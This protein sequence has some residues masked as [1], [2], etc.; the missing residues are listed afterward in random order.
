[1]PTDASLVL[2]ATKAAMAVAY[3]AIPFKTS[4]RSAAGEG[5]APQGRGGFQAGLPLPSFVGSA[6]DRVVE[7]LST[8]EH[9]CR[10][11]ETTVEYLKSAQARVEDAVDDGSPLV[12]EDEDVREKRDAIFALYKTLAAVDAAFHTKI[13]MLDP[14]DALPDAPGVALA[15]GVRL[16][17]FLMEARPS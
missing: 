9:V 6:K 2:A 13:E 11:Y 3:P 16:T 1:M 4:K 10:A 5:A 8:F 7:E 15:S 14:Y 12:V 17:F